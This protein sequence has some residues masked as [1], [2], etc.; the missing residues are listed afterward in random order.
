MGGEVRWTAGEALEGRGGCQ[1][2]GAVQAG[3]LAWIM[4]RD[5]S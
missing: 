3:C 4:R 1:E 2:I 5:Y